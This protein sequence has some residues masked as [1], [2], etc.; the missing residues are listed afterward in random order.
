[1]PSPAADRPGLVVVGGGP[2]ALES[3]RAYREAGG[4]DPVTVLSAD[5]HPP[6]LRPALSK[7]FLSGETEDGDDL[8]LEDEAFFAEHDI[9]LQLASRVRW[10]DPDARTVHLDDD[11]VRYATCVL[12][13]GSRATRPDLPGM[14]TEGV[15]LL[16]SR[17]SAHGLRERARGARRAVVVG[18]GFIGCEAAATLARRGVSVTLVSQEEHPQ[19]DRLGEQVA[20]RLAG[21]LTAEGVALHGGVVVHHIEDGPAVVLDD[22]TRHEGELVLV[23]VGARP[24]SELTDGLGGVRLQDGR[25]LVDSS[26]RT[27]VPGLLAAGDCALA[28]NDA[29]ARRLPVEHWGE[30]VR[31]GEVAGRTAAGV[32]DA[33]AQAPG[34]WSEIGGRT[35][36]YVAW[37][38]GY[39]EVRLVDHPGGG[40]TA[41][42]G[43]AGRTVG[44]LTHEADDDYERG[45]GL[46]EDAAPLP[47][48]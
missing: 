42:Y 20:A 48:S 10:I 19:Q 5:P 26:M 14:A 32:S 6:Y 3:A 47:G 18:S 28:F 40:F 8:A 12:A 44:A 15:H 39:D 31:M 23:C 27:D 4:R 1:M 37:G 43:R 38:D 41:W 29:A 35:L 17:V 16:R 45:A 30:A 46:V 2:T 24:R 22:G 9:E 13:V 33:W 25:V 34:F 7:D 36:K 11:T 21:W